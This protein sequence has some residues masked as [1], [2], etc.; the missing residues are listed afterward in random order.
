M[1]TWLMTWNMKSEMPFQLCRDRVIYI[2]YAMISRNGRTII[3]EMAGHFL[4]LGILN[5]NLLSRFFIAFLWLFDGWQCRIHESTNSLKSMMMKMR[6][7]EQIFTLQWF[8]IYRKL[9]GQNHT[10]HIHMCHRASSSCS[11]QCSQSNEIYCDVKYRTQKIY[12]GK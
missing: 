4:Q 8:V 6:W 5:V 1:F 7:G 11:L 2:I 12:S 10:L 9:W 3:N